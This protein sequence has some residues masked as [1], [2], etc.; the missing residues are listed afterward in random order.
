MQK[1][2]LPH[3]EAVSLSAISFSQLSYNSNAPPSSHGGNKIAFSPTEFRSFPIKKIT[4]ISHDTKV[5]DIAL[6][7]PDSE[8]VIYYWNFFFFSFMFIINTHNQ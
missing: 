1:A 7:T 6:P 5:F 3:V 2:L 4:S 8:M